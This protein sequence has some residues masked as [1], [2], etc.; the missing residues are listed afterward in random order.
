MI[1]KKKEW[2]KNSSLVRF[3]KDYL[4]R[5]ITETHRD[6][7]KDKKILASIITLKVITYSIFYSS[8]E[9]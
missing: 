7:D 1:K 3:G 4:Q 5:L 9:N 2:L 8:P 6:D